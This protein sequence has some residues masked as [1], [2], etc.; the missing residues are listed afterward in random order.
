MEQFDPLSRFWQRPERAAVLR[1]YLACAAS[2]TEDGSGAVMAVTGMTFLAPPDA[3]WSVILD[4][5]AAAPKE[6]FNDL[7]AGPVEGF[8]GRFGEAVIERVEEEAARNPK[9]RQVL[10]GV[11]QH[12]M[13]PE[14][15]ARVQ[16]A[17][18]AG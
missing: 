7:A 10:H 17:R 1:R 9:F 12:Q 2:G 16:A 13:S 5:I 18:A 6:A 3:Q 14:V 15:W 11:W 8:L 4:L